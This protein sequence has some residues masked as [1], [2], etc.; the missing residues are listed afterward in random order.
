MI[1]RSLWAAIPAMALLLA[2]LLA[3]AH[4]TPADPAPVAN[5][6]VSPPADESIIAGL[7]LVTAVLA[8]LVAADDQDEQPRGA[9]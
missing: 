3:M 1:S 5:V 6:P 7:T 8:I 4:S 2:S 9:G